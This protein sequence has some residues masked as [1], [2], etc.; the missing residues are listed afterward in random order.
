[1]QSFVEI[2]PKTLL[3]TM[4][5]F[6]AGPVSRY[7]FTQKTMVQLCGGSVDSFVRRELRSAAPARAY[8]VGRRSCWDRLYSCSRRNRF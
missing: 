7:E 8:S 5:V 3:L 6:A 2:L 4:V 1:M